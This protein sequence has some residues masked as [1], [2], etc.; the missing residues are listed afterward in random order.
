MRTNFFRLKFV[1]LFH[2]QRGRPFKKQCVA[3]SSEISIKIKTKKMLGTNFRT[4]ATFRGNR[5]S[6]FFN[7]EV[8]EFFCNMILNEWPAG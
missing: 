2:R 7:E 8:F 5:I 6:R 1:S 3:V 4:D